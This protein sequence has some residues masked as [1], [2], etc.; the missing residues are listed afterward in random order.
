MIVKKAI[1]TL[2]TRLLRLS[3]HAQRHENTTGIE[4]L[5]HGIPDRECQ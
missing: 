4:A 1:D 5:L 2:Y 3:H